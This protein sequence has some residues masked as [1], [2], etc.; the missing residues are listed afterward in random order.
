MLKCDYLAKL[1]SKQHVD[2]IL[3]QETHIK[4]VSP[5]SKYT[6]AGFTLISK[7]PTR[8]LWLENFC[9]RFN[10][11]TETDATL[12]KNNKHRSTMKIGTLNVANIYKPTTAS[13]PA[14]PL[15]NTALQQ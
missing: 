6:I 15:F 10:Y 8:K 3:L 5:P 9:K 4:D 2:F 12:T 7:S 14:T 13:W 1:S 11:H